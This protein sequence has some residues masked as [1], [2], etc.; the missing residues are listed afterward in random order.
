MKIPFHIPVLLNAASSGSP[1]T[2]QSHTLPH[3]CTAH[4]HTS[5]VYTRHSA[6]YTLYTSLYLYL[7][8]YNH[9]NQHISRLFSSIHTK[10]KH[11]FSIRF[12][13]ANWSKAAVIFRGRVHVTAQYRKRES[14]KAHPDRVLKHWIRRSVLSVRSSKSRKRIQSC[15]HSG[16]GCVSG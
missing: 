4:N 7:Y 1:T 11:S 9:V 15:K 2:N 6:I 3:R 5:H 14:R 10:H 12:Y 8:I 16:L 13:R